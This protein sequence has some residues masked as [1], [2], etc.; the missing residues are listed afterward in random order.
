MNRWWLGTTSDRHVSRHEGDV[1]TVRE[2]CVVV[3]AQQ[4]ERVHCRTSAEVQDADGEATPTE[5]IRV[6]RRSHRGSNDANPHTTQITGNIRHLLIS[7]RQLL[8]LLQR[9]ERS[10]STG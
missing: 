3:T 1:R 8:T 5:R 10:R 2:L 9:Y 6:V 4:E 7:Q